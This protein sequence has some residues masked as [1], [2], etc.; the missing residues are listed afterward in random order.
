MNYEIEYLEIN[1]QN[2]MKILKSRTFWTLVL[3]FITNGISAVHDS[4]PQNWVMYVDAGLTVLAM[5]FHTNPK[6]KFNE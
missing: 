4:I 3:M 5:Y 2:K 1:K 6:V